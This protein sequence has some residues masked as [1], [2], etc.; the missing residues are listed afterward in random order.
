MRPVGVTGRLIGRDSRPL[1]S[2]TLQHPMRSPNS[3]L[4]GN[5]P[6]CAPMRSVPS[7]CLSLPVEGGD[8]E[9]NLIKLNL[10][11]PA[12]P[13]RRS[14]PAR[15]DLAVN[16]PPSLV[17]IALYLSPCDTRD[18]H[19]GTNRPAHLVIIT[20]WQDGGTPR[21]GQ[22]DEHAAKGKALPHIAPVDGCSADSPR[23]SKG[24]RPG[25]GFTPEIVPLRVRSTLEGRRR[26]SP[27]GRRRSTG[28]S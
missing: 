3:R 27:C 22:A 25:R 12:G 20:P 10:P 28:G 9:V 19:Q 23:G 18:D 21:G 24:H 8:D 14:E 2:T 7:C 5:P 4:V 16:P 11:E 26:S 6:Q 17:L 13:V 1:L 15:A